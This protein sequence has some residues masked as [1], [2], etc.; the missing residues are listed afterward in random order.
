MFWLGQTGLTR[1]V[2]H[3]TSLSKYVLTCTGYVDYNI[4]WPQG[5]PQTKGWKLLSIWNFYRQPIWKMTTS[6]DKNR[7]IYLLHAERLPSLRPMG[8]RSSFVSPIPPGEEASIGWRAV[9]EIVSW[10]GAFVGAL[11]LWVVSFLWLQWFVFLAGFCVDI[12]FFGGGC[13][14]NQCQIACLKSPFF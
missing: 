9:G 11:E 5:N 10:D 7:W 12:F 6:S 8:V 13:F 14:K 4:L 1:K 3:G 2:Y